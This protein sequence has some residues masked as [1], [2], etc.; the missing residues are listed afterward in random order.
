MNSFFPQAIHIF[1][2]Y[3]TNAFDAC[4]AQAHFPVIIRGYLLTR[5][6]LTR[7]AVQTRLAENDFILKF[8][9]TGANQETTTPPDT[10]N[11]TAS[12]TVMPLSSTS[13]SRKNKANPEVGFGI[14]GTYTTI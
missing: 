13:F 3:C 12:S 7:N 9:G 14:V 5:G 4:L 6:K 10:T 11:F 1:C 8:P 2:G